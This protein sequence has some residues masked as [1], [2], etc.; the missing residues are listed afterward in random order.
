MQTL[1]VLYGMAFCKRQ[2]N[3]LEEILQLLEQDFF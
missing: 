2:S 1:G 3:K